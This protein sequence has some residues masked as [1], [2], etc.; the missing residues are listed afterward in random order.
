[1]FIFNK[2]ILLTSL[3]VTSPVLYYY[4]I[5]QL[6]DKIK[7][8]EFKYKK[9]NDNYLNLSRMINNNDN[10][11]NLDIEELDIEKKLLSYN[12]II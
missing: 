2:Y 3:V 8:L 7:K 6:E 5:I 11:K 1:M 4:Y 10:S 9:L 12:F